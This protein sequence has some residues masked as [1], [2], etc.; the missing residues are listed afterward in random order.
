M[1]VNVNVKAA[2]SG[3]VN[4]VWDPDE[5]NWYVA[6]PPFGPGTVHGLEEVLGMFL[7]ILS[8]T[9]PVD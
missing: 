2:R 5:L 4:V 9:A 7:P 1:V 3:R 6:V 8:V